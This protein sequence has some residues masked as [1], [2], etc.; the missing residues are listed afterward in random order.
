MISEL[1]WVKFKL[2]IFES[3]LDFNETYGIE[4]GALLFV[5]IITLIVC[6]IMFSVWF[7]KNAFNEHTA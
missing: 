2:K 1:A 7:F 3:I 6:F 4:L 5:G